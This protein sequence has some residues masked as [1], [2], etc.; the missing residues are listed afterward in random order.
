MISDIIEISSCL[1]VKGFLVNMNIEKA[2]GFLDHSFLISVLK[3]F[4]FGKNFITWIEILVKDQQ[5]CDINGGTTTHYFSLERGAPKV[6]QPRH[7][8]SYWF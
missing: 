1:N 2:F 4:C 5:S 7:I 3:R 8:F 6:T